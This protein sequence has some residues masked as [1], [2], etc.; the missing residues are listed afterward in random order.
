MLTLFKGHHPNDTLTGNSFCT[1]LNTQIIGYQLHL[2]A[3][4]PNAILASMSSQQ[5]N[6]NLVRFA[7]GDHVRWVRALADPGNQNS[8][9]QV[10]AVVPNDSNLDAFT[11]YDV[12][13]SFGRFTLY[14]TQ[15]DAVT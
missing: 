10:L 8:V 14:G 9:G 15:V 1:L 11:I 5:I 6:S 12:E 7:V 4:L 2:P 3:P 13:F